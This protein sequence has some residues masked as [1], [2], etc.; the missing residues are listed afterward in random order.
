MVGGS[1]GGRVLPSLSPLVLFLHRAINNG[2]PVLF[3]FDS[4]MPLIKTVDDKPF[5]I[6][7]S[8][9]PFTSSTSSLLLL[10]P[11]LF[12]DDQGMG[13]SSGTKDPFSIASASLRLPVWVWRFILVNRL[14]QGQ[15]TRADLR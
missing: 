6:L 7:F 14:E 11:I 8:S 13:D 3:P 12:I 15:E 10:S 9:P 5:S 2:S 4:T 1:L